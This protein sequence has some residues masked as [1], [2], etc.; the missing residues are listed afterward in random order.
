MLNGLCLHIAAGWNRVGETT[1]ALSFKCEQ[2]VNKK[3]YK[4][5]VIAVNKMGNSDPAV[6]PKTVL[7]K[8]PWGEFLL[9]STQQFAAVMLTELV[10]RFMIR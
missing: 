8:D 1:D 10:I 2:L 6:Y 5:R 4:F 9:F 3:E 7:A